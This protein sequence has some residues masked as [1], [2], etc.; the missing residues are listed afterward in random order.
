MQ[1]GHTPIRARGSRL[2]KMDLPLGT[3]IQHFRPVKDVVGLCLRLSTSYFGGQILETSGP[4][5]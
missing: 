3:S 1:K 2:I 5:D 4:C